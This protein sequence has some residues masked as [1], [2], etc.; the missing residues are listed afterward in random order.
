MRLWRVKSQHPV[1]PLSGSKNAFLK[2]PYGDFLST[3][4]P[5][6][7]SLSRLSL[8]KNHLTYNNK[9]KRR[10]NIISWSTKNWNKEHPHCSGYHSHRDSDII[11]VIAMLISIEKKVYFGICSKRISDTLNCKVHREFLNFG[12]QAW[13]LF[14]YSSP[15]STKKVLKKFF[16]PD[17]KCMAS[18]ERGKGW[19]RTSQFFCNVWESPLLALN[20][21][22]QFLGRMKKT[23]T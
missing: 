1:C 4:F 3:C 19:G 23:F 9:F 20:P 16:Q 14:S 7:I 2:S 11:D 13:N 6:L 10:E 5:I 17:Q 22:T 18:L 21:P 12:S 15:T 8:I